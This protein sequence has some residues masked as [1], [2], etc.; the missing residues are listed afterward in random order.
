VQLFGYIFNKIELLHGKNMKI[1]YYV[2]R[3]CFNKVK[4]ITSSCEIYLT[5]CIRFLWSCSVALQKCRTITLE[6]HLSC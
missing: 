2:I 1:I 4:K 5:F 3:K 6:G